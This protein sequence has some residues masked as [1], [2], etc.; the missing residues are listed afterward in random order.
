MSEAPVPAK[1]WP[2]VLA[3]FSDL[4]K[5]LLGPAA[6]QYGLAWGESAYL[7][8]RK[9]LT[10]LL[11]KASKQL[12]EAKIEPHAVKFPLLNDIVIEGAL[13]TMTACKTCGQIFSP[14]LLVAKRWSQPLS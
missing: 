11:E 6:E 3:P 5:T 9:R 10:R 8:R 13:R 7:F 1:T 14:M 4:M 12:A 2:D